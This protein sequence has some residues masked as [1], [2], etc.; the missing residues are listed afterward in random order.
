MIQLSQGYHNL[1]AEAC[2]QLGVNFSELGSYEEAK[3]A[4]FHPYV[5]VTWWTLGDVLRSYTQKLHDVRCG[6]TLFPEFFLHVFGLLEELKS[7]VVV[8][9]FFKIFHHRSRMS[10]GFEDAIKDPPLTCLGVE[11]AKACEFQ[12]DWWPIF[13]WAKQSENLICQ[14]STQWSTGALII[15][16]LILLGKDAERCRPYGLWPRL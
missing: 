2:K 13:I 11:D 6:V 9:V 1:M 3:K 16:L 8:G 4:T 7:L 5:N 15:V 14:F 10:D 12:V